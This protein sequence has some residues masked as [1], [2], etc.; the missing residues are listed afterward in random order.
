LYQ[1]LSN[2]RQANE[3]EL[4]FEGMYEK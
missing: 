4:I 2:K 3:S 1:R